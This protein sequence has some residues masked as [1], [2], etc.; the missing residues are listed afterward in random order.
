MQ[1]NQDEIEFLNNPQIVDLIYPIDVVPL[2]ISALNFDKT[3]LISGVLQGIK[4]QY[5]IFDN[6]VLNV[7]KFAGY[8]IRLIID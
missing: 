2:K 4:G 7:R 1:E 8:E 3:P 5:L 6:G